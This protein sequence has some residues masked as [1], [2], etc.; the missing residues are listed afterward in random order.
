LNGKPLFHMRYRLVL[1]IL[2]TSC[3]LTAQTTT[4]SRWEAPVLI[5]GNSIKYPWTGGVNSPQISKADLNKDGIQD[6]FMFDRAGEVVIVLRATSSGNYVFDAELSALFPPL[7]DWAL[8]RDYNA[9]GAPDIFCSNT[10]PSDN[11]IQIFKGRWNGSKLEF[12][13][14]LFH[15]P[16]CIACEHQYVYYPS[17][18]NPANWNNLL[19]SP[20]DLPSIKDNDGDGD[21]DILTFDP[22]QGGNV[23]LVKNMSVEKGFGKD[24][25]HFTLADNCYGQMYESG[26]SRCN[27][28]L[29]GRPDT[30][31]EFFQGVDPIRHPGSTIMEYDQDGDGD[32]EL[33]LGDIS[34]DC[35][36]YLKNGGTVQNAWMT[37]QDTAFPS[38]DIAVRLTSF[39][40][41]FYLD[42]DEDGRGDMLVAPNSKNI[43]DDDNSIWYYRNEGSSNNH[44]FRRQTTNLW[45]DQML[46]LGTTTHPALVDVNG[47]GLLDLVAGNFGYYTINQQNVG[48]PNNASLYLYLNTGTAANPKFSLNSRNW[49]NFAQFAP[50]DYDFSPAFG[51]LDNDG[52]LDLVVGSNQGILYF[53]ENTAGAGN[54]MQM[55]NPI[56]G[57]NWMLIDVGTAGAPAIYDLDGDGKKDLI[58]GERPGNINFYKNTGSPTQPQFATTP[59]IQTLG[60]IDTRTFPS[61]VGYATPLVVNCPGGQ[62]QL[63]VGNDI[64]QLEWYKNLTATADSIPQISLKY[65]NID[66]GERS[67]PALGDL[68]NDGVY[69][70]IVGNTRGGF[71]LYRTN[72]QT[73]C[74]TTNT[75]NPAPENVSITI[76]PNPSSHGNFRI[77]SNLE[78]GAQW[79]VVNTLGQLI[80]SGSS[81]QAEWS[82]YLSE[83]HSAG[84][85]V[86]QIHAQ[87]R[88]Y[89]QKLILAK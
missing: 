22:D 64:G 36:N 82:V 44:V 3:I 73:N 43:T 42:I 52:D 24:S 67:H 50:D 12:T 16:G 31:V 48:N 18:N 87:G 83:V 57:Y 9:D 20:A 37:E 33:V 69:D 53:S 30:C 38:Y 41:A 7:K 49:L 45:Q 80:A 8:I 32:L 88:R 89:T 77:I 84:I 79:Q 62:P 51:D 56:N 25:L 60:D 54:P 68:D 40:A 21:L 11:A 29:S 78:Q 75:T 10:D 70:L 55:T 61:V 72:L 39:P 59:T 23:W 47:D 2:V 15:Y 19:V 46:D 4:F 65:G 1:A 81:V 86:L 85:Y 66:S 27:C 76:L 34:F 63:L 58:V 35:L 26:I 17:L 71:E 14:F 13:N 74:S 28:K 6:I 5:N